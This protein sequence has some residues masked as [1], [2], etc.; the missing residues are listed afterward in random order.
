[1]FLFE[2]LFS[3]PHV[4]I[5]SGG[6][7]ASFLNYTMKTI[8]APLIFKWDLEISLPLSSMSFNQSVFMYT[9]TVKL[10]LQDEITHA[11]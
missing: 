8:I 2:L 10:Q 1:M 9:Y 5:I 4:D 11:F 7:M 6:Y 3:S